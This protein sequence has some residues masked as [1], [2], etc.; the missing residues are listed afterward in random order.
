MTDRL[1]KWNP[2]SGCHTT[3][4]VSRRDSCRLDPRTRDLSPGQKAPQLALYRQVDLPAD[5]AAKIFRDNARRVL[6]L[7]EGLPRV[8]RCLVT[9]S[10][11]AYIRMRTY[12]QALE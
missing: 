3:R 8:E 5:V 9:I 4:A 10:A 6:K 12:L 2:A 11:R 7:S 1:M